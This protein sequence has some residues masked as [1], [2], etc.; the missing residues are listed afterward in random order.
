MGTLWGSANW[1]T[2]RSSQICDLSSQMSLER[3]A[4]E[5]N[6]PVDERHCMLLVS[7]L[8]YLEER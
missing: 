8:E 7:I 3:A 4:K 1:R 6:S 5:G 2:R